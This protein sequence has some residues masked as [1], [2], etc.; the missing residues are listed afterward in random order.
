[1]QLKIHSVSGQLLL[2]LN[3]IQCYNSKSTIHIPNSI[4]NQWLIINILDGEGQK[5]STKVM[6]NR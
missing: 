5:Y 2:E 1:L 4:T 6:L 3:N